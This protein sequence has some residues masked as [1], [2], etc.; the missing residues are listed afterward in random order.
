MLGI[1]D[2]TFLCETKLT[3]SSFSK[4]LGLEFFSLTFLVFYAWKRKH[5]KWSLLTWKLLFKLKDLNWILTIWSW[6]SLFM[7][8]APNGHQKSACLVIIKKKRIKS[9]NGS[10]DGKDVSVYHTH[11][12]SKI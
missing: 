6:K 2:N 5:E 12:R 3:E 9:Y 11:I 8:Y 7:K 10:M 1:L 4:Y